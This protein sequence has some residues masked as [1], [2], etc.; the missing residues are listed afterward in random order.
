MRMFLNDHVF[1]NLQ[2]APK[3]SALNILRSLLCFIFVG[4]ST[5]AL[6]QAPSEGLAPGQSLGISLDIA[7]LPNLRDLGG[8]RTQDGHLISRGRAYRTNELYLL[9]SEALLKLGKLHLKSDYDLRTPE[10]IT[11]QP[12]TVPTGVQYIR[13]NVMAGSN[14]ITPP[15]QIDA[16][17][18]NPV[19]ASKQLGGVEGVEG[20]F[21]VLYRD[22]VVLPSAK[23]SYR[24]LFLSLATPSKLPGVFH[25][26]NGKDRTGW[27]AA[28]LLTFLGV[29][30]DDVMADYLRSNEYLL[31]MHQKE[32]DQFIAGGGDPGIPSAL[33]GVK[34]RYL[35]AAFDEMHRRYGNIDRYFLEGLK[36]NLAQQR[37]LRSTFLNRGEKF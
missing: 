3:G 2:L 25:C 36:I 26:T 19:R 7:R 35:E 12:D 21:E 27:A 10:E 33:F 5:L 28:A 24:E 23:K 32:I 15:A 31:P 37:Q 34:R 16:L 30:K 9:D 17:L 14:L 8:Y 18:Q 22:F 20:S 1:V 4:V 11:A 6:A 13:L 29:S